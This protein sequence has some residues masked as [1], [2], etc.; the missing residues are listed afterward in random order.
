M[1]RRS[2]LANIDYALE[3]RRRARRRAR[4]AQARA[5]LESVGLAHLADRARAR[6]FRRRA[7][8]PRARARVGAAA[9][10]AVPRRA[11]GEP[12]PRRDRGGRADHP[13]DP[14]RRHED[15]D[16]HAQPRAG[17]PPRR[18]NRVPAPG[19]ARRA[20]AGRTVLHAPASA[21]SRG[22]PRRRAAMDE[23]TPVR[24]LAAA[25]AASSPRCRS[26]RRTSSSP[27]PRRPRPSSRA[28]S[29]T[30][31]RSSRRT[32]AS[33][34]ASSR[35]APA[36]RSTWRG[37]ATPT[38][39]SCTI[40]AAEEKFVAEGFGVKHQPVMYNDFV[41]VG[42]KSDPAKVAGGKD[43]LEALK[44]IEAAKAPFVSRGDKSGTHAAELRYWKAAGIDLDA[45]KG[46][47]YRDTG[48]GMG[49]ALNTASSMNAYVLADRGTWLVVQEPRRPRD[50]G[51]GR[52]E[53]LQPVR[54]DAGQSGQASRTSRRTSA[55]PSSTGSSRPRG[56][57]R[58]PTTRSAA[59][60]SS[61]RT[62]RAA[63]AR[64]L[65]CSLTVDGATA[66]R[67]NR[68]GCTPPGACARR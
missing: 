47:W 54:R 35:S 28:C 23:T 16:D 58:S 26:P 52:P 57:R 13:R 40:A 33:R 27:S 48:S 12:R 56:R 43:M 25:L 67:R 24:S 17:A 41:L 50:P 62:T 44:K 30:C 3:A 31:C 49:P 39:C 60:S 18:R 34:C 19:A 22:V 21:G 14:R 38:W 64:R 11:D 29:A 36:K 53:A 63:D 5:A 7:A 51:R 61:S 45:K 42:P 6:A 20:C 37:A 32:P 46:P 68:C 4:S 8:A 2:A 65:R 1:L 59:S 9:R 55:R 66:L 15:R 10:G